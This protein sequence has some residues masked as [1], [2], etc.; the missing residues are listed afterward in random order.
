M[1]K[2]ESVEL[3]AGP[4]DGQKDSCGA[5]VQGVE[6]VLPERPAE[7]GCEESRSAVELGTDSELT[8]VGQGRTKSR[9]FDD[10][11]MSKQESGIAAEI[12]HGR[13]LESAAIEVEI[14]SDKDGDTLSAKN[15]CDDVG[16]KKKKRK[17]KKK[18]RRQVPIYERAK[19]KRDELQ[20][21]RE[22]QKKAR[23]LAEESE[24]IELKR[25]VEKERELRIQRSNRT[26]R[27]AGVEVNDRSH[28]SSVFYKNQK[29]MRERDEHVKMLVEVKK[30]KEDA[31]LDFD[32]FHCKTKFRTGTFLGRIN[33][34]HGERERKQAV[35]RAR[36]DEKNREELTF[37]PNCAKSSKGLVA[38]RTL[39][40]RAERAGKSMQRFKETFK[41]SIDKVTKNVKVRKAVIESAKCGKVTQSDRC[42]IEKMTSENVLK[43]AKKE[44]RR[45]S[46][47]AQP[48]EHRYERCENPLSSLSHNKSLHRTQR[49]ISKAKASMIT[50]PGRREKSLGRHRQ[51][52]T[53]MEKE[54]TPTKFGSKDPHLHDNDI[55]DLLHDLDKQFFAAREVW[56]EC[57]VKGEDLQ[58]CISNLV[59][60]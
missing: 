54:R 41:S 55:T 23:Q 53:A 56:Q 1:A 57:R 28:P 17:K 45:C 21:W 32:K 12:N 15:Q 8:K 30:A 51:A 35:L 59:K 46:R 2:V 19:A 38:H 25:K 20:T 24:N 11:P 39:R 50:S 14:H 6:A 42:L 5:D 43:K 33:D 18:R 27:N 13:S 9:N 3:N 40:Q 52:S 7:T 44:K 34:W 58:K 48:T 37:H 4:L 47:A 16:S 26:L 36:L 10:A 29:W 22:E 60:A 31:L 49:R